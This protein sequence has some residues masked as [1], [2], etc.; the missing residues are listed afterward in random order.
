MVTTIEMVA[1]AARNLSEPAKFSMIGN[2]AQWRRSMALDQDL[3]DLFHH[4]LREMWFA[5]RQIH[6]SLPKMANA[7]KSDALRAAFRKHESETQEQ[8]ARLGTIFGLIDKSAKEEASIG[9]SGLLD[10]CK[11]AMVK[12]KHSSALDAALVAQAQVVEH[13]EIA[14]YGAMKAWAEQLGKKEAVDLLDQ[15]LAEEKKADETL[16]QIAEDIAHPRAKKRAA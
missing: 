6:A 12:F 10:D 15:T 16:T 1:R 2:R 14:C 8:I 11:E 9:L 3:F 5:E 7:A 13:Y 4:K